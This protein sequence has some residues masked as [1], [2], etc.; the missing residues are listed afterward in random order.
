[1]TR[2][3]V[4][5][6]GV[7]FVAVVAVAIAIALFGP[8]IV[9]KQV[10]RRLS[11]YWQGQ[12]EIAGIEVNYFDPLYLRDVTFRDE[13]GRKWAEAQMI[14]ITLADWPGLK[15]RITGI[16]VDNLK[17]QIFVQ[18]GLDLPLKSI[19][20]APSETDRELRLPDIAIRQG[21]I[22]LI[23]EQGPK[24]VYDNVTLS[25]NRKDG[26]YEV[27]LSRTGSEASDFLAATGTVDS[28]S[29]EANM[30]LRLKH[31]FQKFEI[32]AIVA[33]LNIPQL[34]AQGELT[35]D[36]EVT[37][38]LRE[39]VTLYP[40]GTI[41]LRDWIFEPND[42]SSTRNFG[43]DIQLDGPSV[44][45]ENLT[46]ADAN[47]LSWISAKTSEITLE[48]W[49]GLR[50]VLTGIDVQGLELQASLANGRLAIPMELAATKSTVTKDKNF[51]LDRVTIG[52]ATVG[53][54]DPKGRKVIL[55]NLSFQAERQEKTYDI[56]LAPSSPTDSNTIRI[57][58]TLDPN[59]LDATFSVRTELN[60]NDTQTALALS[61]LNI[62]QFAARGG[63]KTD[64][65]I[66]GSLRELQTLQPKGTI[67]LQDWI[68]E[69]N[70][71]F[72]TQNLS[73]DIKLDGPRV[74][75][76]NFTIAD[77]NG[78]SWFSANTSELTLRDWPGL[79][80]ALTAIDIEGLGV[81][82]YLE[83][84][85]PR[86]PVEFSGGESG[87]LQSDCLAL[88][89]LSIRDASVGVVNE[90]ESMLTFD[91][92]LLES[93]EQ[94]GFYNI[95][96]T[97]DEPNER[98]KISVTGLVNPSSSE[99]K[100]S[101]QVEHVAKKRETALLF[102]AINMPAFSAHGK[103]T[104]DLSITGYLNEPAGLRPQGT[105]QF[106]DW[107]VV[108]ADQVLVENLATV[109][110][111]DGQRLS[112]ENLSAAFCRGSLQG[113]FYAERK[114]DRRITLGGRLLALQ[115]SF[116]ELTS[117]LAGPAKKAKTGTV[118][119]RYD[120]VAD[121]NDL[122]RLQGEGLI[123]LDD[124][125]ITVLP[126]VPHIFAAVGLKN[127]DP[128]RMSDAEAAFAMSG[129][130][131]TIKSAHIA[132]R[133]AAIEA[134]PG[135]TVNLRTKRID[136]HAVVAPLGQIGMIVKRIPVVQI[137]AN[138][139]DRLTR[140][141]VKGNW[142]D[143]PAKLITKEPIRDIKD[144]TVGFLRDVAKTGGQF[145]QGMLQGLGVFLPTSGGQKE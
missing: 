24:A 47:G 71:A 18:P 65:T 72:S 92:L 55:D 121:A 9:A 141:R 29:L 90:R 40:K 77:A 119:L 96:V 25:V 23:D 122:G 138:L 127:L 56:V 43:A 91:R 37:S 87:G 10:E 42:T 32:A 64:L 51:R 30:S 78:L 137:V 110:K 62:P 115:A 86:F 117:V 125:D 99:A 145:S 102:G 52:D 106:D 76:E 93:A 5:G 107:V 129:P 66:A 80:P 79:H 74:W 8:A 44:R 35:A 46:V 45:L 68:I 120:F 143:P 1:M 136:G 118:T 15:P 144:A 34:P 39:P 94:K 108:R 105:I 26:S 17:L 22:S 7:A 16:R 4:I 14:E 28:K 124:A 85:K 139:K 70:D 101:L 97:R 100:L 41:K 57:S 48:N 67:K 36:L 109:A 38:S 98:S 131:V 82:A 112:T 126:V 133:L 58:G 61:A 140:L 21:T 130:V 63:L 11:R 3:A 19:P 111:I 69:P 13:S 103:L 123:V 95:L 12:I 54:T 50:P 75:L 132:N 49:P 114:P 89:K 134:E 59:T 73:A 104:A 20:K 33:A 116:P 142:S 27:S 6:A 31:S 135:G 128:L 84:G 88:E 2:L 60:V 81:K 53:I 83:N 113:S